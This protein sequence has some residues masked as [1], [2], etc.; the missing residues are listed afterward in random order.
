MTQKNTPTTQNQHTNDVFAQLSK[1]QWRFV[2]AMVENPSFS[3][4]D[5]ANHINITP[6]TVYRWDKV[7]DDAIELARKNVHDAALS[8]RKQAVLE[9][10]AVK[11]ALLKSE[12][13]AI[14]SKAASE[15]I[16]W[17]L[18]KATN[19]TDVSGVIQ[20]QNTT[21]TIP[22][23]TGHDAA[24]IIQQL[25]NMGVIPPRPGESGHDTETE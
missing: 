10:I 11:V 9:A 6:D 21:V 24:D 13:E 18:G 15:I 4:K 23:E 7:V 12:D 20:T 5:G 2:T 3:K 1:N 22:A 19:R 16:E 8:M 25:A 17:E 14:R